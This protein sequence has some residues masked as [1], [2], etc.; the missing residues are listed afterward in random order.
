MLKTLKKHFFTIAL[1]GFVIYVQLPLFLK[2]SDKEGLKLNAKSYESVA[3]SATDVTYP[4]AGNALAIFWATWCAPCKLE[5]SRLKESVLSGKIPRE[6]VFAIN[7][8]EALPLQRKYILE[9]D[10]PFQ[11]IT[12]DEIVSK[13]ELT[14]TPTTILTTDSEVISVSSGISLIG[15]W[16]AESFLKQ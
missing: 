7:P 4:P 14:A 10:Y 8:F 2:N 12:G 3:P 13:L 5:M 1:I 6:K 15:I 11:F 9:N 16:E